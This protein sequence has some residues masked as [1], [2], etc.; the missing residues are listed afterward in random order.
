M[1]DVF[2]EERL[3]YHVNEDG[4]VIAYLG[5]LRVRVD[6]YITITNLTYKAFGWM[7]YQANKLNLTTLSRS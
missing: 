5:S 4:T 3:W 2:M 1:L 6:I 7:R